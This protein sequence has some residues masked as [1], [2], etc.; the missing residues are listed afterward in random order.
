MHVQAGA[1]EWE[2]RG[3]LCNDTPSDV[4]PLQW[5]RDSDGNWHPGAKIGITLEPLVRIKS[6]HTG[7]NAVNQRRT[8]RHSRSVLLRRVAHAEPLAQR[9]GGAH[10]MYFMRSERAAQ[11]SAIAPWA[12]S[13]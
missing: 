12:G 5:P 1:S 3:A 8:Q 11:A 9:A 13:S 10:C 2:Y 6:I 4:F 7:G